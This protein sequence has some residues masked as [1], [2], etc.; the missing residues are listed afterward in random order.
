[1]ESGELVNHIFMKGPIVMQYKTVTI[2]ITFEYPAQ[3]HYTEV[4]SDDTESTELVLESVMAPVLT[5]LYGGDGMIIID[6]VAVHESA[7]IH[8]YDDEALYITR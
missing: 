2:T 5:E 8:S 1:M 3:S 7:T 4:L 6:D